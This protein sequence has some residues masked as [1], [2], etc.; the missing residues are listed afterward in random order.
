[1]TSSHTAPGV[2]IEEIPP[3]SRA[4]EGVPTSVTAFVGRTLRGPVDRPVP[5]TSVVELERTFGPLWAEA[6]LGYAVRAFFTNGGTSAVVVRVAKDA[7]SARMIMDGLE[8]EAIGPGSWGDAVSVDVSHPTAEESAAA[9]QALGLADGSSLF[10]LR[11]SCG[12]ETE[13]FAHVSTAEGSRS[14]AA[15]LESSRLARVRGQVPAARPAAGAYGVTMVGHDGVAP[16]HDSYVPSDGSSRGI[17]A[18]DGVDLVNILVLPPVSPSSRLPDSIWAPALDYAVQRRAFLIVDLPPGLPAPEIPGWPAGADLTGPAARNAA[19][20]H[21]RVD[22]TDP[23]DGVTKAFS[24]SGA[25]AGVYARTDAAR[26]VWK[27]PAGTGASLLDVVGPTLALTD[28][29]SSML[30]PVG[31]NLI[32]AFPGSGTLI[33]GARTLAGADVVADEYMYVPV[34]R[35]ALHIEES[36][37]RGLQWAAFEP[38]GEPLWARLRAAVGE[39]LQTLFRHGAL[40]GTTPQE[41]YFVKCDSETTSHDDIGSGVVNV[42]VGFAALKPAEFVVL[43]LQTRAGTPL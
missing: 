4:V 22:Q 42:L 25:V 33:W 20:Y 23:L 12:A 41:A 30:N 29:D 1:M 36:L 24:A 9:A 14:V 37:A 8:L 19:V 11:L 6:G 7:T 35:L 2:S 18:L 27:A 38:N 15:V 16:D 13:V 5:V 40:Q 26:G 21:P 39:F 3:G 17:R 43:R 32:R 10:T 31:V 34:R 28:A